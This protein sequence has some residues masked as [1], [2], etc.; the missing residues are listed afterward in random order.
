[1][2]RKFLGDNV[3]TRARHRLRI[4]Y[5]PVSESFELQNSLSPT[6]PPRT[7]LSILSLRNHLRDSVEIRLLPMDSLN[8]ESHYVLHLE[9]TSISLTD[10]NLAPS[11]ESREATSPLTY[12]FR[13]FLEATGYGRRDYETRSRPFSLS[14]TNP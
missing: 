8:P 12:L 9:I 5:R 13:S 14:E 10:I 7:F 3:I 6:A 11:E 2:P 4:T 1:I